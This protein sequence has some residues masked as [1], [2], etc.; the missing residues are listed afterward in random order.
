[1]RVRILFCMVA[2]FAERAPPIGFIKTNVD[3]AFSHLD[4]KHGIGMVANDSDGVFIMVGSHT[5]CFDGSAEM[6]EAKAVLRALE[7][8]KSQGWQN[9][10]VEGDCKMIMEALYGSRHRT[11]HVQTIVDNCLAFYYDFASLSFKFG[12]RECNGLSDEV[13]VNIAPAWIVNALYSEFSDI[14][15]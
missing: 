13:W 2:I 1:M 14:E 8:A 6:V 4:D 9:V 7:L 5:L 12:Y 10:N 15:S 11:F 3:G